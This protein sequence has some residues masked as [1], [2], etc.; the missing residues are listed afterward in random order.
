MGSGIS[1]HKE[2]KTVR[3]KVEHGGRKKN[4]MHEGRRPNDACEL[5]KRPVLDFVLA[6]AKHPDWERPDTFVYFESGDQRIQK[7]RAKWTPNG[8]VL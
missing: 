8:M 3:G 2:E 4:R 6:E 1:L 5:W 7:M